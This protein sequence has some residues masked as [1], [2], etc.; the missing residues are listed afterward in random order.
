MALVAYLGTY[1]VSDYEIFEVIVLDC[2]AEINLSELTLP[3]LET[4]WYADPSSYDTTGIDF[5]I[6]QS[7]ACNYDYV[8]AAY[9]L[10]DGSTELFTLP[11]NEITFAQNV[12][13]IEKCNPIG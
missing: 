2:V 12:F 4:R 1:D 13:T 11:E 3:Y 9:W 6:V 5:D 7:P 8:Y 10:P